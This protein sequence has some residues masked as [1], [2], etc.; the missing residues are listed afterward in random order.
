MSTIGVISPHAAAGP[1]AE[2][3]LMLDSPV[4]VRVARVPA[5]GATAAEPGTPPT[6]PAG[7]QALTDDAVID[8]AAESLGE[9]RSLD[10]IGYASTTTGYAIGHAAESALVTRLA[11][12]CGV[13][14]AGTS[15]AAVDALRVLGVQRLE[16][17]H[18]PWF[19]EAMNELGSAY[20]RDVGLDVVAS[21]SAELPD[22][23]DGIRVDDVIEWSSAHVSDEASAVFLGG[24]GFLV[25]A[26]I[27]RLEVVLG[28]PVLS[29][30]QVLL[31]SLLGQLP[32]RSRV[33]G[34]GSL[35]RHDAPA[36]R[37]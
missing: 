23:P 35:F 8:A 5:P 30:N 2:W 34:Y 3:P 15:A 16:L 28:R 25:A 6:A 24:N 29:A 17:V 37:R 12:R 18:P 22:D 7:L 14:V 36:T 11:R 4:A 10:A 33:S 13:P 20:F 32:A 26:A 21:R 9:P 31:W 19:D 27:E 1:E